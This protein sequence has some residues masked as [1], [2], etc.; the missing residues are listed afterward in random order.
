MI[1]NTLW[2][3]TVLG[4][5]LKT[6]FESDQLHDVA[7]WFKTTLKP[8]ITPN[9]SMIAYISNKV[10]EEDINKNTLVKTLNKADF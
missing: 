2:N 5:Y 8:T 6:N 1:G 10:E 3:N 4:R 7:N 9:T